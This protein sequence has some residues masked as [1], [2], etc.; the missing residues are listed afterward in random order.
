MKP[1]SFILKGARVYRHD[2]DVDAPPTADVLVRDGV[3]AEIAPSLAIEDVPT[4]ALDGHLLA[5][6]FVN[7]HYHSHDVL[8]KGM[9]ETMSLERWGLIAGPIGSNRS[10]EEVRLRTMLGAIECARN[11]ITTIQDFNNIAPLTP[12]YVDT[13]VSAYESVGVRVILSLTVRDKSQLDT[14]L[15]AQEMLP[16]EYHDIVGTAG[17][18]GAAQLAFVQQQIDRVGDRNGGVVWALSPSAPQRCS[19]ELVKGVA[20]FAR[21]AK[22]PVYTHVYETRLQRLFAQ[23]KLKEFNGSAIQF[24]EEAGLIG[25][26]VNIAHGV[27]PDDTEIAR[28]AETGTGVV[29]NMLSNLKLRSGV[30]P[31]TR[32]RKAGVNLSLGCDNCSCSDAQSMTQVMKLYCLLGGISDPGPERPQAAEA[33]RL[34]T[35]GGARAAGIADRVGAIEPGMAADL[36][37]YD[38]SDPAWQPFNSAARQL[39]FAES[40]RGL[41]HV[42]VAGRH[43][44]ADGKCVSVDEAAVQRAVAEIM[45]GLRSD[46]E[47]LV[48]DADLV[49]ETFQRIQARA[50]ATDLPYDRY[51]S[52]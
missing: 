48:K 27:W 26:H 32:Y 47:K 6:G 23:E 36:V 29:L 37:A 12:E 51:L 25:P 41:R 44:V 20:D 3:I 38:L 39:V 19:F 10:L 24:M 7:S 1:S 16:P 8:A 5:P 43:I 2:G 46:I 40:G 28:L 17:G 21:S 35:L 52:R 14:I 15:W 11:G 33:L 49:E 42:W 9:F 30:A 22:L 34:A 45:P 4:V 18:D 31:L 13:V 50:F